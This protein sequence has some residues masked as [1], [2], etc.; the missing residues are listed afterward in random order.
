MSMGLVSFND[1]LFFAGFIM[2][3]LGVIRLRLKFLI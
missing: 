2:L 3:L 1:L